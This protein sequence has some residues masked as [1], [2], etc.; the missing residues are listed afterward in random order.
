LKVYKTIEYKGKCG[1]FSLNNKK[2]ATIKELL[3]DA[4]IIFNYFDKNKMSNYLISINIKAN[5]NDIENMK[6]EL[7]KIKIELFSFIKIFE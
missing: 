6:N 2:Y 4:D 3:D 5:Q 1:N 7:P